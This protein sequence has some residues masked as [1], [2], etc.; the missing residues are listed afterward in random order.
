M[1]DEQT[2]ETTLRSDFFGVSNYRSYYKDPT[3]L[4]HLAPNADFGF[5][6]FRYATSQYLNISPMQKNFNQN[7]WEA[8]E[9]HVRITLRNLNPVRIDN[10]NPLGGEPATIFTGGFSDE[11]NAVRRYLTSA[12]TVLI[13]NVFFKLVTFNN[14]AVV[15]F[16]FVDNRNSTPDGCFKGKLGQY[17]YY[18]CSVVNFFYNFGRYLEFEYQHKFESVYRNWRVLPIPN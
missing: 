9:S 13:S 17:F 4:G 5:A 8:L 3:Q 11:T 7:A 1:F 2:A 12:N 14:Q 6:Y 16:M 18:H 10:L 15:I